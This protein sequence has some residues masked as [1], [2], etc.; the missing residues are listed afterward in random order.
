MSPG[1]MDEEN[2]CLWQQKEDTSPYIN[3]EKFHTSSNCPVD[4]LS[5]VRDWTYLMVAAE[6]GN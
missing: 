3:I 5:V 6:G 4:M 1:T 2:L